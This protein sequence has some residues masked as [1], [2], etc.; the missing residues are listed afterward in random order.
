M[1]HLS[2]IGIAQGLLINA[3]TITGINDPTLKITPAGFLRA[4]M[5]NNAMTSINN[6]PDLQQGMDRDIA[7]RYQQRGNE[8]EVTT[9]DDCDTPLTA[10]WK[11]TTIGRPMFS[12]IGIFISDADMRKY[13]AEATKTLEVTANGTQIDSTRQPLML[14]LYE[15]M[16][17]KINALISHMDSQLVSAQATKWGKNAAYGDSN[18]H[19]LTFGTT[20]TMTDGIVKLQAD[21]MENEVAGDVIVVGNGGVVLNDIYNRFKTGMDAAGIAATPLRAYA[22]SKTA[23]AWGANHFGAFAK[24]NIGLVDFCKYKGEFAGERGDSVFFTLP[25]P[26][27]LANGEYAS[28]EFDCQ[29]KYVDCPVYDSENHKIAD[30]GYKLIVSKSYGLFNLPNDAFAAND[31]L[32]GVNGAF[33]YIGEVE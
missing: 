20:P 6:L 11:E 28:L 26:T 9:L 4:L 27:T 2:L 18:A 22:D 14:G 24:G 7:I 29:L 23:T 16:L 19:T 1:A 31:R 17:A 13:E 25:V 3:A 8:S 30:R 32:A 33:H 21:M 10:E 15:T 5:E 12:K